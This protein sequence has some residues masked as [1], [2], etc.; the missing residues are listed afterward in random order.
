[1]IHDERVLRQDLP[2]F[3]TTRLCPWCKPVANFSVSIVMVALLDIAGI[4]MST[5]ACIH[6]VA[7]FIFMRVT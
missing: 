3:I 2:W 5:A 1:M 4:V 6:R 7:L